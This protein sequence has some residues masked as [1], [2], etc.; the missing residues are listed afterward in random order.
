MD[1][2][3]SEAEIENLDLA[4][5]DALTERHYEREKREDIR[6]A[7]LQFSITT[8]MCGPEWKDGTPITLADFLPQEQT[9][10]TE[11]DNSKQLKAAFEMMAARDA[12][13]K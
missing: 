7:K 3:L 8:A 2:G 12:S 10:P 6:I 4:H 1:L 9:Q 5:Y 13:R 11:Q